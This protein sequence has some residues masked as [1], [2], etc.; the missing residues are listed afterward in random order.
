M[1]FSNIDFSLYPC[2][3]NDG[4]YNWNIDQGNWYRTKLYER[5]WNIKIDAKAKY[6]AVIDDF[7]TQW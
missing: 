1:V 7:G 2:Y 4:Y 5:T 3:Y 6:Y